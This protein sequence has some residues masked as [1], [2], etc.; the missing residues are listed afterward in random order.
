MKKTEVDVYLEWVKGFRDQKTLKSYTLTLNLFDYICGDPARANALKITRYILFL[1]DRGL[2]DASVNS[3]LRELQAFLNW[4]W[5]EELIRKPVKVR[6]LRVTKKV[7]GV[8]TDEQVAQMG[9]R[10]QGVSRGPNEYRV[11][12]LAINTGMRAAEI[13]S[14]RLEDITPD[15]IYIRDNP[16]IGFKVKGRQEAKIQI[17]TSLGNFLRQDVAGR[18]EYER[19]YLDDG[20]GRRHWNNLSDLSK[21]FRL[22]QKALDIEGVKP[23]HGFR[24]TVCTKLL[25]QGVGA[26]EVQQLMR[27]Q[28]IATTLGYYNN[29]AFP[30]NSIT[31]KLD[32]S[33]TC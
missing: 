10:I 20:L 14:L 4:A 2:K 9:E 27:H 26:F 22:H 24:A 3:R 5:Q 12:M 21:R 1:K 13:M 29:S 30:Q 17:N 18:R 6:R 16:E 8:Y 25:N 19:W 32:F 23:V 7:M 33:K 15:Y 31:E 11:Y 28:N